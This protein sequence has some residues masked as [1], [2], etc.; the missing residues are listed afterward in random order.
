[1]TGATGERGAAG[2]NLFDQTN[3]LIYPYPVVNRSIALGSD[4]FSPSD[5]PSTT[6][7]ASALILL[8]GDTGEILGADTV[9]GTNIRTDLRTVGSVSDV[10]V[11]DTAKDP[12]AG[13]WRND[14]R[15]KASSWY[16]ETLDATAVGCSFSTNDRCGR[17]EFPEKVIIVAAAANV[18][19][20]D[21]KDNTMW[22]RF[23]QGTD[24][25]LDVDLN[26]NPS[27][28]WALNGKVYVATNGSAATGLY[29]VDFK[30]D[31]IVRYNATD[32]RDFAEKID[33]RNADPGTAY[34]DQVRTGQAIVNATVNDAHVARV[35]ASYYVVAA[36]DAGVSLINETTNGSTLDYTDNALDDYNQVWL[37]AEGNLWATNET[38]ATLE[39]W[40]KVVNDSADES[41]GTPDATWD[42]T[43]VPALIAGSTAPTIQTT[44]GALFVTEGTST[45]DGRSPT[46]YM[47]TNVG[48]TAVH[49]KAGDETNGSVKY[50]TGDY[51]GEELVGDILNMM[52]FAGGANLSA[53][54]LLGANDSD[55]SDKVNGWTTSGATNAP[56]T[57]DG[58]RGS[59]LDFDASDDYVCTG[60]VAGTCADDADLDPAGTL[61]S[62]GAWFRRDSNTADAD[63]IIAKFG[64]AAADQSFQIQIASGDTITFITRTGASV[65]SASTA[66][67]TD[68]T[69]W[70]FVVGTYDGTNQ[71]FYVDGELVDTDAQSGN[72]TNSAVAAT[73][74]ADLSG[75]SNAAANF[76]DGDIDD[77][78][79]T[80]ETLSAGQIKLMYNI[81][82][83]AL[84]N[85]T[86]SRITG[87]TGT[88][89]YQ[90]LMGNASGGT[91]T[92]D[93]VAAVA[94][95]D[96]REYLYVGLTDGS[97]NTG[98]VT[99]VGTDSDSAVDLYDATAN[100]GKDDDIGTQFSANDVVSLSVAGSPCHGYNSGSTTCNNSATLA[101][102]GTN[103]T[104]TRVWME[105]STISDYSALAL[106]AG[107]VL[108]KNQ[109]TVNNFFRVYNTFSNETQSS[110]GERIETPALSVDSNG[111]LIYNYL[112]TSVG[113]TAIDLNDSILTTG[114]LF[115]LASTS[116]TTGTLASFIGSAITTG[117]GIGGTFNA[118]TTGSGLSIT[119]TGTI[120]TT[121]ELLNL[122]ANSLTTGALLRL[123]ATGL[124]SGTGI[125]YTGS[126]STGITG[127]VLSL[128]SDVGSAGELINLAPDF[129]GS[130]VTGYGVY[131]SGTDSTA[132]ANTDYGLYSTIALTGNAAKTGVGYY[133]TLSTS[134]TTAD[135]I[136][137]FDAATTTT[138]IITTGTRSIYGV[139]TQPNSTAASTG[140]T[141][142]VYGVYSK[143]DGTV[144]A[145]GTINAYGLYVANGTMST[146]GTSTNTGLYVEAPSGAD[147]NYSAVFADAGGADGGGVGIG[148][149]A[150]VGLLDVSGA[151]TGKALVIINETGDQNILTASA[152]GT[153]RFNI[154]RDGDIESQRFVDIADNTFLLDPAA[155]G[156]SLNIEGDIRSNGA[157]TIDSNGNANITIDSGTSTIFLVGGASGGSD[158]VC[159]SFDASPTG[160]GGKLNAATIDPPYTINGEKFATFMPSMTGVK[161]ETTGIV[162][163]SEYVPGVGYRAILDFAGSEKGSDVWLFAKTTDLRRTMGKLVILL[164]PASSVRSWY[165]VD[166]VAFRASIYTSRPTTVSYRLT[167]PRYDWQQW[168][169]ERDG[170][171][172]GLVINDGQELALTSEGEVLGEESLDLSSLTLSTPGVEDVH[173]PGVNQPG[174]YS[175]LDTS[176]RI[177]EDVAA[178]AQA[179][180]GELRVG[181]LTS[182][183]I[184]SPIA[185]IR[186]L[187]TETISPLSSESTG[188]A[189]KL[190]ET[191]TFGIY[192]PEGTPAA[193]FDSQGN[194]TFSGELRAVSLH[195]G[196]DASVS[197]SLYADRIVTSFGDLEER[198]Q[199]LSNNQKPTTDNRLDATS[200]ALLALLAQE[201]SRLTYDASGAA[202]LASLLP[203]DMLIPGSLAVYGTTTLGPTIATRPIYV[204]GTLAL[205]AS[206]LDSIG[207][208]TL[209]L[210]KNRLAD[211]DIAGGTILINTLGNVYITG[212]LAVSGNVSIAGVLGVNTISSFGKNLSISLEGAT[213]TPEGTP[214]S[215]FGSLLI[216][217]IAEKV[218]ASIDASGSAT[219]KKLNISVTPPPEGTPSAG[220]VAY[221]STSQDTIGIATLAAGALSVKIPTTAVTEDSLI[222]ITP[223]TSTNNKVIYVKTKLPGEGVI[224][225]L[226]LPAPTD[227]KFNWW[228]IN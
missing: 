165:V 25:A 133:S 76:L 202:M 190:G 186:E 71:R 141:T 194:A 177:I 200:S 67:Y 228:I 97:G 207:G 46:V 122:A 138:G 45:V 60:T 120:T 4:T 187:R 132:N 99:T 224:V 131:L 109:I 36:T 212:D 116:I 173:T 166:P 65:T 10:F 70:H 140:G 129:S 13:I 164:S 22:M 137:A 24:F 121:G 115:D 144:G 50:Y 136:A 208:N 134:S 155:T 16:N 29:A 152:S 125:E 81:G 61:L 225:G 30:N 149:A 160:C 126:S 84:E 119:S 213:T 175:L 143:S 85:H 114:T 54:T 221:T 171:G 189:V 63:T 204:E 38:T 1:M 58:V 130:G 73:V 168:T 86:A 192:T 49:T 39:R 197:G 201:A 19:L 211:V 124:T 20:F 215:S 75:A 188:I 167:A 112:G 77:T 100:T 108:S 47:G 161:E 92:S 23:D 169:N 180:I 142:N 222:Y 214:S 176:G 181:L 170:T 28:V 55:I 117:T 8:N 127:N 18:Y 90:R 69:L 199:L 53:N 123:S 183:E 195:L 94:V 105:S 226:D 64:N 219:F 102:G 7:T 182:Q 88:N 184:I 148:N 146:T 178:Y 191:Q 223:V 217:G 145:G 128:T 68:T 172:E 206:G 72:L 193:V 96:G 35:G 156:V 106:I 139:R 103:D 66:S 32:A 98:G 174:V 151:I 15:A 147:S 12:D 21:A 42:E 89:S 93:T 11:Y 5:N 43:T 220:I 56:A 26:N 78:F 2:Q 113:A 52:P 153:T 104:A 3:N 218:V 95:S 87:V 40:N 135:T 205:S 118:L 62:V 216:R 196:G 27:S 110:S 9:L 107:P 157:F 79:V 74:G 209:F 31:R 198:L 91:S 51:I 6:A 227:I 111:N 162:Q 44:P 33:G 203:E 14:E 37:D 17:R 210:Q 159:V 82:K 48:L 150:P 57:S 59:G 34:A 41:P 80:A 179:V 158:S 83:R 101:I 154:Q 163:T 185:E